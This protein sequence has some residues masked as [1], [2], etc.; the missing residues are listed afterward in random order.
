MP[1]KA[2]TSYPYPRPIPEFQGNPEENLKAIAL[3][4]Y[5]TIEALIRTETAFQ[6]YKAG[7]EQAL[8]ALFK[9]RGIIGQEPLSDSHPRSDETSPTAD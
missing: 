8:K 3:Q 6:A 9:S 2:K 1:E 7:G 5:F 4:E